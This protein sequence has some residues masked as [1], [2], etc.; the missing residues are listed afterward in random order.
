MKNKFTKKI[1]REIAEQQFGWTLN[2]ILGYQD[3]DFD[4]ETDIDEFEQNFTEDL[5]EKGI[6]VTPKRIEVINNYYQK[7]VDNAKKVIE[8]LYPKRKEHGNT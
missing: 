1:A 6:I 7:L 3:P 5:E 4:L 2:C 8:R